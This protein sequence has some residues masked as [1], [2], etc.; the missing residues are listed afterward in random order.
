LNTQPSHRPIPADLVERALARLGERSVVLVGMPGAG[1][2]TIGRRLGSLLRLPFVDADHEIERAAAMTI[3]EI[4]E[5]FGEA[6]FREG[7][8][9]V[10]ARLLE[11]GRQVIATG[12]GAFMAEET[13]AAVRERAVS[14]WLKADVE[15]LIGRV[16]RKS[17]RPLLAGAD[18]EGALRRLLFAREPVYATADVTVQSRDI[19]HDDVVAALLSALARPAAPSGAETRAGSHPVSSHL[20]RGEPSMTIATALAGAPAGFDGR[21]TVTVGLGARAYD[22]LIGRGF[23]AGAEIATRFPGARASIVT[24]AT[25]ADRHLA[26]FTD[27]LA[28]A[29]LEPHAIVVPPGEASKS[30]RGLEAVVDGLLE[31]RRERGD[32]VVA[33]GGGVIGDLA[34]F[35]AGIVRRGMRM[36]QVPTTVLA[37]VDSSVGGK[38]GINARQGKNL[39]GVFHQPSLVLAD[40]D[41]LATLPHRHRRA[42]YAEI[43][44]YGLIDDPG[45][46]AWLEEHGAD[47]I[48]LGDGL[49]HAVATSCRAKARVVIADEHETT[50]ARALLNL[51]H[52]FGHALEAG[53]GYGERLVHGEAVALGM[54]Q[55][56]RF[57][58]ARGLCPAEDAVRVERH[59]RS[60]GLPTRLSD[61][62]GALPDDEA[63]LALMAQDKKVVRGELVF[64]LATGI[65]GAFLARDVPVEAVRAF[66]A[67]ERSGEEGPAD[68]VRR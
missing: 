30:F 31:A 43:A 64:V 19:A 66:L 42:G 10:I 57:S 8:K 47:V 25:V 35:A 16:R 20:H 58:A 59:L 51:G 27:S 2:S 11:G 23:D 68:E 65:G 14:V 9:R 41:L 24:D 44:K 1:K 60:V 52:T 5:K 53:T 46:F 21:E 18:P 34:G 62:P 4:F 45:F 26:A 48:A 33:L 13:R 61:V 49:A 54:A 6:E 29:G 38:T 63:L 50:G 55:A 7:E 67:R 15:T 56:F 39:V 22:I 36:V 37:Q 32:L 3:P 40:L 12:G 28:A 17:N